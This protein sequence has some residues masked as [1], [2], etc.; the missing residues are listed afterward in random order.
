[1]TSIGTLVA[2]L[3]V[4]IGVMVLRRTH[5]ELPRGF[6]VPGYPVT[7]ILSVV[8]CLWI[9]KDLRTVTIEVFLIWLAVA[10]P[11]TS[12]TASSTRT[13]AGTSTSG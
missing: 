8:G 4:S 2:F 10:L 9:I 11:S 5:P 6:K 12:S 3:V 7:P 1:M 13:S